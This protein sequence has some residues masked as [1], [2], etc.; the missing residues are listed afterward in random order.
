[1]P[2]PDDVVDPEGAVRLYL[3]YIEDPGKLRDEREIQERTQAVLDAKDPIDKL[4][5]LA[6]LEHA[7]K[8]DEGPLRDG[9]VK[10]AKAW[11]DEQSIPVSAFRELRVPDDVLREAGFDLPALR[12]RGPRPG[13]G[14]A[15]R[16][17]SVPIEVVK[18]FVLDH[19]GT[20]V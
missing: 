1:M 5:A 11:A 2:P 12:R 8:V 3:L 18:A 20:F 14:T 7:S 4:K 15:P 10:V 16:A 6:D 13:A 19:K 17:K 9:F